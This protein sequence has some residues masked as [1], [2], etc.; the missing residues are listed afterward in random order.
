M[1]VFSTEVAW[2]PFFLSLKVIKDFLNFF[3][4]YSHLIS[5]LCRLSLINYRGDF[6]KKLS[7]ALLG[8]LALNVTQAS[9]HLELDSIDRAWQGISDPLRM[10]AAFNREFSSLPLSG[11]AGDPQKYWSSDYW[12]R[13]KGGINYRWNSASPS[14]FNTKS[15]TKAEALQM[16]VAQIAALAPSEKWD[17]FNG[18]YDYP[19]KKRISSY[20]S[21]SRPSWEG[22]CDG[23][24]GAA[25]N[26]D[27]PRPMTI[28]NPDGIQIPFGSSDIKGLLSWYYAREWVGGYAMMGRRCNGGIDIGT[29]RC[30][31]DMNAGAFHIVL[32]NRLGKDGISFIADIDRQSEVWNHLAFDFSSRILSGDLRPR[33]T[34]ASGTVKVVRVR[35]TVDYVWLLRR[36][37]WGPVLGTSAQRTNSR[38]YEYYLDINSLGRI[39]G[40]DWITSQRPDFL[41]LER[42]VGSFGGLFSRLDELLDEIPVNDEVA[43]F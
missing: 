24:A 41:W 32:A 36:N 11:K 38:I 22:I 20:A 9:V 31:H 30:T 3:L 33:S 6:M 5:G 23:W 13:N 17:L 43:E 18:R 25:L 35:T 28:A 27:E 26:H 4:R 14:G 2:D 39:I 40:G 8:A 42:K 10:S 29:D 1:K 21:P 16:T 34:S 7:W 15:P 37:A 19:L 12:A